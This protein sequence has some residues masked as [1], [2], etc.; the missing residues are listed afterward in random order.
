MKK[1]MFVILTIAN[2]GAERVVSVLSN[3]LTDIG[4]EV[5]ILLYQR[6]DNEYF[7]NDKV[8][9]HNIPQRKNELWLEYQFSRLNYIRSIM[10]EVSP[11]VIIPFLAAP[12]KHSFLAS[13]GLGIPFVIT[14]R[15]NPLY[16]M[17]SNA[18]RILRDF[19]AKFYSDA[20]FLQNNSQMLYFDEAVR[21]KSFVVPNPVN[22][23]L[24]NTNYK[25]S[26]KILKF[27]TLG[28][29]EKQKN[30]IGLIDAFY[31]AFQVNSDISLDI[32][33]S[34]IL[35]DELQKKIESLNLQNIVNLK[36]R[37][38]DVAGTLMNYHAFIMSSNYE[39]MP[40][41]LMEAM[42]AGL[43]CIS[44]DCPTGPKELLGENERGLLVPIGDV[45]RMSEAMLY[46]VYHADIAME[47]GKNARSYVVNH[48]AV[49]NIG[50]LFIK[51]LEKMLFDFGR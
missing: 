51:E 46:F 31:Q 38:E 9:I 17:E 21:R 43:P 41:A 14:V 1:I 8:K 45:N 2:G 34:G 18:N 48:F 10:K 7:L 12:M 5:D 37:T 25:Y 29:L 44:T 3:Y 39:G 27:V 33:G 15:N 20:V 16:D 49:E 50:K 22:Q 6:R 28:R 32:Y 11:D 42:C 19:I 24:V 30:H 35:K 40:N 13:L 4:Y 26:D 23:A 47:F 36:G